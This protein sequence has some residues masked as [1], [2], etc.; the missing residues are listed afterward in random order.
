MAGACWGGDAAGLSLFG[1]LVTGSNRVRGVGHA[2]ASSSDTRGYGLGVVSHTG[3]TRPTDSYSTLPGGTS[4][5]HC[6]RHPSGHRCCD[7]RW[8]PPDGR[9]ADPF[10]L[11]PADADTA[12]RLLSDLPGV[13]LR[14]V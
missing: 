10:R 14:G 6:D 4:A 2:T 7:D 8:N 11:E 13:R 3:R 12:A 1:G 5:D 9:R